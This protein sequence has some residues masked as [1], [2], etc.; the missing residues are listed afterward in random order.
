MLWVYVNGFEELFDG[1]VE[2][3]IFFNPPILLQILRMLLLSLA[4]LE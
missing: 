4:A 1:L 3:V 2:L